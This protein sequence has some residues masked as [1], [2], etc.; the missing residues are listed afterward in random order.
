MISTPDAWRL[1]AEVWPEEHEI[2]FY[3]NYPYV[4][5]EYSKYFRGPE[6][7]GLLTILRTNETG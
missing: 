4:N 7:H 3:E 5:E 1:V 6:L 2:E